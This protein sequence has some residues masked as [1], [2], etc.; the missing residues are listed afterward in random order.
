MNTLLRNILIIVIICSI[1]LT[2]FSLF[3]F[4]QSTGLLFITIAAAI[5]A[6]I[7]IIAVLSLENE[8]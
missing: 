6:T 2:V 3:A 8:V 7:T 1:L 4:G 5:G